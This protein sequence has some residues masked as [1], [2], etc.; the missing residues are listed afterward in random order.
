[1]V[2]GPFTI[3]IAGNEEYMSTGEFKKYFCDTLVAT[4]NLRYGRP[5]GFFTFYSYSLHPGYDVRYY[6]ASTLYAQSMFDKG[7]SLFTHLPLA[8]ICCVLLIFAIYKKWYRYYP[9]AHTYIFL[10]LLVINAIV[11]ISGNDP[12]LGPAQANHQLSAFI[13]MIALQ[14]LYLHNIFHII[15]GT[16]LL[17]SSV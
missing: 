8:I 5:A 2:N 15:L 16:Y 4:G 11:N 3:T 6:K 7:V 17:I 10:C 12:G 14:M 9:P 1:M 13:M